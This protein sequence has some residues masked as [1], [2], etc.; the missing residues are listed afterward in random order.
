[1]SKR[2]LETYP[3]RKSREPPV[4]R[5]KLLPHLRTFKIDDGHLT[6]FERHFSSEKDCAINALQLIDCI[7]AKVAALM[8]L[9]MGKVGLEQVQIEQVFTMMNNYKYVYKF[10]EYKCT[11]QEIKNV[12]DTHLARGYVMF[13][14]V[15]YKNGFKHVTVVGR[16]LDGTLVMIDPQL[17]SIEFKMLESIIIDDFKVW[18]NSI[19]TF[20]LLTVE[21]VSQNTVLPPPPIQTIRG[22]PFTKIVNVAHPSCA[23]FKIPSDG[24]FN[25]YLQS[26][27]APRYAVLNS[28]L[29]IDYVDQKTLAL[30]QIAMFRD[31]GLCLEDVENMLSTINERCAFK[32]VE[33]N[34][35]LVA[36][37]LPNGV[38]TYGG[39]K[40][41]MRGKHPIII[42]KKYDGTL[43]IINPQT[44][45]IVKTDSEY[46]DEFKNAAQM[47]ILRKFP[48]PLRR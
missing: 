2:K 16:H 25:S 12:F 34:V 14:G 41:H 31:V 8:R 26:R 28:F 33:G 9:L 11:C 27:P 40:W 6:K 32:F 4:K 17:Q 30:L 44:W 36:E 1:M 29:V 42:A 35:R 5:T 18:A 47:F 48:H 3:I 24:V 7:D 19:K 10:K 21:N 45:K 22:V 46:H 13:M 38:V 39:V 20:Y 37:T 15:E 43:V 23:V